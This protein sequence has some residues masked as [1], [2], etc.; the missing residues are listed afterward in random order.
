L[1]A[2]KKVNPHA[3]KPN[4]AV[5]L[6]HSPSYENQY[7]S[8]FP[9]GHTFSPVYHHSRR[10]RT[11]LELLAR[12]GTCSWSGLG[13]SS[14][15]TSRLVPAPGHV[16]RR[17]RNQE[18]ARRVSRRRGAAA[19]LRSPSGPRVGWCRGPDDQQ[20]QIEPRIVCFFI[21]TPYNV[22]AHTHLYEYMYANP[23]PMTL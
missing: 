19:R 6:S 13:L 17:S 23:T 12:H 14:A 4:C 7:T 10:T 11:R 21:L 1:Q 3:A 16:C 5:D 22:D 2:V 15:A 8:G 9:H 18:R 20:M